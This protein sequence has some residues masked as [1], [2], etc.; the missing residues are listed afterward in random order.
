VWWNKQ[1]GNKGLN[2]EFVDAFK[3]KYGA[4]PEWYQATAY[5]AARA[6]LTAIAKAG[7]VDKQKVRDTLSSLDIDSILPGGKLTF[8]EAKGGQAS[9]PFVVQQN[10]P[11]GSSPII[12]P[13]DV[14][15]GQGVAPNPNCKA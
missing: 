8:P 2:K 4:D 15:T 9:Y 12:F 13:A 14:A 5:E 10:L 6:L 1:L 7:S 11:D 3:A